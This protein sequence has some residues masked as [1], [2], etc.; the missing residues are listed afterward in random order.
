MQKSIGISNIWALPRIKTVVVNAGIGRLTVQSA[1][2][3]DVVK[4]ISSELAA[5]TGQKPITTKAKKSIASFKTR[6][7]MPIG[8]KITLH[9]QRMYD[10]LERFINI[11]LPRTRDF[12]G[13]GKDC[14][15]KDGN[16]NIGVRD[17]TVFP[18]SSSDAAHTFGFQFTVVMASPGRKESLEFFRALGL[19]FKG[20]EN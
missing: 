13:I 5:I 14:V 1:K 18:E 15:D 4:R 3:E 10:F 12:R 20:K 17:H 6:E 2:P 7:G 11:A 16:L 8:L 9:G 19:P